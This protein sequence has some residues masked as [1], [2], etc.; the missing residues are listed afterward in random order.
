[1]IVIASTHILVDDRGARTRLRIERGRPIEA[2]LEDRFDMTIGARRDGE[3]AS[4]R[5][6][7]ALVAIALREP[8]QPEARSVSVLGMTTLGEDRFREPRGHRTDGACPS[9]DARRRPFGMLLV[10]RRHVR[11]NRGVLELHVASRVRPDTRAPMK[12]LHARRRRAHPKLLVDE[13][14]WSRIE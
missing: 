8:E 6:F 11:R 3:R 9:E 14:V 10:R 5:G 1:M 7:D 12:D 4:A 13:R 2:V